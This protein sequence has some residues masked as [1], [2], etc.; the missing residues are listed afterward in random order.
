[1]E[2]FEVQEEFT[3]R[4]TKRNE[5]PAIEMD[6]TALCQCDPPILSTSSAGKNK[7]FCTLRKNVF[8]Q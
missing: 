8:S 2:D 7:G 4:D 3:V 1:M 6:V 5:L